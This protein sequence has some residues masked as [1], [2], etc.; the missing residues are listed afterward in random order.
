MNGITP[1][2]TSKVYL[3]PYKKGSLSCKRLSKATGILRITGKHVKKPG[4]HYIIWGSGMS[5]LT[6][7]HTLKNMGIHIPEFTE[8]K[9]RAKKWL[10]KGNTVLARTLLNSHSGKGIIICSPDEYKNKELPS[11]KVYTLYKKKKTEYRVHFFRQELVCVQQKKKKVGY[12]HHKIRSN[13]N[14]YVF[15]HLPDD[16]IPQMLKAIAFDAVDELHSVN[17]A[18]VDVIYNEN[19]DRYYVLEVNTA[20]GLEGTTLAKYVEVIK[21]WQDS[22]KTDHVKN[23]N[24]EIINHST[25]TDLH[26]VG[27]VD[28]IQTL[29][30]FIWT[31]VDYP[32]KF[33]P[34]IPLTEEQESN[35]HPNQ[36]V[37]K[38]KD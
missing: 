38:S 18:A 6:Q 28:P 29:K 23:V 27:D 13:K 2:K 10:D 20:P 30:K 16:E 15:C 1:N 9:N 14:G 37:L 3:V 4:N 7:Y 36:L 33:P 25:V 24:P 21:T 17:V 34:F 22:L 19:E 11:A 35:K 26:T 32:S 12:E 31:E 5:K 8:D